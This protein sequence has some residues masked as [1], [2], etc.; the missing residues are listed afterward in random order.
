MKIL[1]LL[2]LSAFALHDHTGHL[3]EDFMRG[4]ATRLGQLGWRSLEKHL[5]D[6]KQDLHMYQGMW[7]S[8]VEKANGSPT[9]A[10][11][12]GW[13]KIFGKRYQDIIDRLLIAK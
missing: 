9:E 12:A 3:N 10:E 13:H 8:V 11:K 2:I 7:K 5:H 6:Y 1:V 4:E